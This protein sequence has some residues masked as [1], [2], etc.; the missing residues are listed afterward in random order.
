MNYDADFIFEE[1][2]RF[3]G[4]ASKTQLTQRSIIPNIEKKTPKTQKNF[5]L[6][7]KKHNIFHKLIPAQRAYISFTSKNESSNKLIRDR[8][9]SKKKSPSKLKRMKLR[10]KK[11]IAPKEIEISSAKLNSLR[12]LK[13][14]ENNDTK[15]LDLSYDNISRLITQKFKKISNC[16]DFEENEEVSLY[17]MQRV[18]DERNFIF[19]FSF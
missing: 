14:L 2:R 4:L 18:F 6:P 17:Y 8:S 7:L 11:F 1:Q 19:L 9:N 13:S 10:A 16:D 5:I 3:Q 15:P 12:T